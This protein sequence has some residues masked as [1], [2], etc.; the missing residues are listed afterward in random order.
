MA[1]IRSLAWEL[2]HALDVAKKQTKKTQK[3][4]TKTNQKKSSK[5]MF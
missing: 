3:P 2:T 5:Q 1:Q 4:K